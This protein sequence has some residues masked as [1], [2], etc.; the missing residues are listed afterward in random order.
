LL[1]ANGVYRY[2][3]LRD[4]PVRYP[5]EYLYSSVGTMLMMFVRVSVC[6]YVYIPLCSRHGGWMHSRPVHDTDGLQ[7]G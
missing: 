1:A 3:P 5:E 4:W 7:S 6:L 2:L